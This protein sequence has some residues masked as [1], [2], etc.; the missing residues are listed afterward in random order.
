MDKFYAG[1]SSAFL[2]D[3]AAQ[4][5]CESISFQVHYWGIDPIHRDNPVHKHSF[6]EI[7]YVLYGEGTYMDQ[8]SVFPLSKETMFMSRPGVRHQIRSE[9]GMFILY[10]GFE[11]DESQSEE[12]MILC[13]RQLAVSDNFILPNAG[14]TSSALIW[15]AL[16]EQLKHPDNMTEQLVR[17]TSLSLLVSFYSTFR[18]LSPSSDK[19]PSAQKPSVYTLN[20]AIRFIK[21]NLSQSLSL[22]EVSGYLHLSSRHLSRLF[23]QELGISYIDF[24]Q[25]EKM[26]RAVHLLKH[27]GLSIIEIAEKT[28]FS[29]VHYFTRV[30]SRKIGKP[31]GKFREESPFNLL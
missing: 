27:T 24:V 9:T 26:R 13:Y 12:S 7:C 21:D 18:A 4:L 20:R 22:E 30:F 17:N 5:E 15:L 2:N 25:Q 31:P 14:G 6:F 19:L 29:N 23:Q 3:S 1:K 10:V 11:V 8:E 28:G 16:L